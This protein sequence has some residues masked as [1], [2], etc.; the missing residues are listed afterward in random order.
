MSMVLASLPA[1]E[2]FWA[3]FVVGAI[4]AAVALRRDAKRSADRSRTIPS[5]GKAVQVNYAREPRRR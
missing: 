5:I 1:A 3:V 4:V 2:A